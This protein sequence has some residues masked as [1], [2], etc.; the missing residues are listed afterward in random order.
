MAWWVE[1]ILLITGVLLWLTSSERSDDVW[2]MFQKLIAILV[3]MVVLLG[4]RWV[5]LEIGALM[6]AFLLPSAARFDRRQG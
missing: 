5:P 2:D 1:L 6:L 4:G 3:V